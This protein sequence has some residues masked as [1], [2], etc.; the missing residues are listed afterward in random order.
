MMSN[1]PVTLKWI[2]FLFLLIGCGSDSEVDLPSGETENEVVGPVEY[3]GNTQGTTYAVICNDPIALSHDE[4]DQ[5][6]SDF[7]QALSTYISESVISQLNN[8]GAGLFTYRDSNDYF[9]RCYA[10]AQEVYQKTKGAFDPTIYPLVDGWGFMKNDEFVPDSATV[11]SL[12][13]L[14]SFT[15]GYHFTLEQEQL[16]QDSIE[17]FQITKHTLGAKLDFN[18]I[19]QGLAVD[20]LAELIEA[21]GGENYFVEIGGE[22]RVNGVNSEGLVWKIGIDKPIENSTAENRVI[23]EV[24]EIKNKSIATSGSYRKF[25]ERNGIKYSHTID[26]RTGYPVQ[27]S[28]LSVTVVAD[29]CAKADAMA[30]AFMVMGTEK[31]KEWLKNNPKEKIEAYFIFIN[32]YDEYEVYYTPAFGKMILL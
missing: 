29:D 23:Q 3:Y 14:L 11:D 18:A 20:V 24:V 32:D 26:P 15:N 28:L 21:N 16:K 1:I 30:T 5:T 25:Y 19:A 9:N 12:R 2:P 31:S 17:Q 7:D 4:I 27:H 6:L 8:Q 10:A 22:I 13:T